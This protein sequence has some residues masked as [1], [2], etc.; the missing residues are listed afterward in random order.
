MM[1]KIHIAPYICI[2]EYVKKPELGSDRVQRIKKIYV[3]L[4]IL[5]TALPFYLYHAS[6]LGMGSIWHQNGCSALT[7]ISNQNICHSHGQIMLTSNSVKCVPV[8]P[9]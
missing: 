4:E 2:I 8:T 5:F 6:V 7:T 9:T 3:C 1:I